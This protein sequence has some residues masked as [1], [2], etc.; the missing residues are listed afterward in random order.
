MM[1]VSLS[2]TYYFFF[3]FFFF[4]E[5]ERG[6]EIGVRGNKCEVLQ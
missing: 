3:F 5:R 1:C 6:G 4:R 2:A